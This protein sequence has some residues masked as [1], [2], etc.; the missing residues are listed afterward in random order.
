MAPTSILSSLTTDKTTFLGPSYNYSQQIM[1]PMQVGLSGEGGFTQLA[2]DVGGMLG[3]IETLVSGTSNNQK[4]PGHGPLG[5]KFFIETMGTCT[6][7]DT[8]EKETRYIYINNVPT[9]NIPLISTVA[10]VDFASF[11]GLVPGVLTNLE[12]LD[13]ASMVNALV[14]G[15]EPSCTKVDFPTIDS[16]GNVSSDSHYVLDEEII[17]MDPCDIA[18]KQKPTWAVEA[19]TADPFCSAPPECT[20]SQPSAPS[21]KTAEKSCTDNYQCNSNACGLWSRR[22]IGY[23]FNERCCPNGPNGGDGSF[24]FN[25]DG[26]LMKHDGKP[27]CANLGWHDKCQ[28]TE[29][30]T[31]I[32]IRPLHTATKSN[33]DTITVGAKCHGWGGG[34]WCENYYYDASDDKHPIKE[35]KLPW[36]PNKGA[37]GDW[38]NPD[39]SCET[40][41]SAST[42]ASTSDPDSFQ[43]MYTNKDQ[44]YSTQEQN[45]DTIKDIYFIILGLMGLYFLLKL[46]HKKC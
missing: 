1:T 44:E 20:I 29:Q 13:P 23:G 15:A 3:Y 24:I 11:R 45:K 27:W 40:S 10:G 41:T 39:G 7:S 19:C 14:V 46:L 37:N 43:N 12:V 36:C 25:S 26:S 31:G 4:N 42:S 34:A 6:A 2:D 21:T 30:C 22:N 32:G 16:S 18:P 9:G 5:N 8:G 17:H 38:G 28:I 35:K 33:G